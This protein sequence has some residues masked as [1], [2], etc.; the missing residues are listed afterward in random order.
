MTIVRDFYMK[1]NDIKKILPDWT[2]T[3]LLSESGNEKIYQAE[4]EAASVT[5]YSLVRAVFLPCGDEKLPE[6][7]EKLGGKDKLREYN[8]ELLSKTKREFAFLRSM[9]GKGGWLNLRESYDISNIEGTQSLLA[10][11]FDNAQPLESFIDENGLTQ[12]AL[13]KMGIDICRGLEKAKKAGRVHGTLSPDCIFVDENCKFRI[14]KL[15]ADVSETKKLTDLST[16]ALLF[17]APWATQFGVNYTSDTYS[18]GL[19]MYYYL[20][21]RKLP[22]EDTLSREDALVKR[23]SPKD[24]PKPKHDIGRITEIVMKACQTSTK[25]R[26]ATP[27]QMRKDLEEVYVRLQKEVEEKK[28]KE[29]AAQKKLETVTK[30]EEEKAKDI[31]ATRK[32]EKDEAEKKSEETM[33]FKGKVM[34]GFAIFFAVF[35]ALLIGMPKL[36]DKIDYK[37]LTRHKVHLASSYYKGTDREEEFKFDYYYDGS[38]KKPG[39]VFEGLE[40][41]VEGEDYTLKYENNV[42]VGEATIIIKGKGDYTGKVKKTFNIKQEKPGMVTTFTATEITSDSVVLTWDEAEN[43]NRYVIY[44]YHEKKSDWGDR[45]FEVD[46]S[47][48]SIKIT[49]LQPDTDYS[50]KIRGAFVPVEGD[51]KKGD[52]V[53]VDFRTKP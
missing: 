14:G 24:I 8:A 33:A 15:D 52:G 42:E 39:I 32:H 2:P 27:Y 49:G 25:E 26:Y 16:Q 36:I 38:E 53:I 47:Q 23:L 9:S 4:K 20:N 13:L 35:F 50:F 3:Y 6:L 37:N 34:K 29:R 22:F 11:R 40:N 44:R 19:I 17:T 51:E 12:G 30:E 28:M 18:V 21:D 45:E 5:K 46:A 41:L 48:L 7:E 10:A 43:V 31:S 1:D